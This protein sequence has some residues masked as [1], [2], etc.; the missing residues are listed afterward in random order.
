M[1]TVKRTNGPAGSP[2]PRHYPS[3][4]GVHRPR[5]EIDVNEDRFGAAMSLVSILV[6]RRSR[7]S[8]WDDAEDR[9]AAISRVTRHVC[10]SQE[11]RSLRVPL[12]GRQRPRGPG[13]HVWLIKAL[14]RPGEVGA[15]GLI[16]VSRRDAATC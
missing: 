7:G 4:I 1:S 13:R 11:D 9:G 6:L 14:G 2:L 16:D 3:Q 5:Y 8:A 10:P 12:L 15:S